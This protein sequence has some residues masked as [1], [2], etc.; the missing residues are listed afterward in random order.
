MYIQRI[1][2]G[3]PHSHGLGVPASHASVADAF[4]ARPGARHGHDVGLGVGVEGLRGGGVKLGGAVVVQ[5][6]QAYG[7]E[8]HDPVGSSKR[9][10]LGGGDRTDQK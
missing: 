1:D 6:V 5:L 7:E 2:A 3:I 9:M 8:L 4:E 10:G